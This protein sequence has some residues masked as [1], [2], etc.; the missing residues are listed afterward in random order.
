[1]SAAI[2]LQYSSLVIG[3]VRS[4]AAP[5]VSLVGLAGEWERDEG[6]RARFRGTCRL[7]TPAADGNYPVV[8]ITVAGRHFDVLAPLLKRLRPRAAGQPMGMI[9]IKAVSKQSLAQA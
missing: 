1:M 5:R 8:N 7:F 4:M 2:L 6:L 3:T 9:T